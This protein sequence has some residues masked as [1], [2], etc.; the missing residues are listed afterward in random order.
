VLFAQRRIFTGLWS[1]PVR[2][3]A[4]LY[5][6]MLGEAWNTLPPAVR[7]MH[8][9]TT[10]FVAGGRAE[11]KRGANILAKLVFRLIGSPPSGSDVPVTVAFRMK[12][13][14]ELWTRNFAGNRFSSFQ[15]AG[16]GRRTH[17]LNERFGLFTFGIAL[18]TEGGKM[19][20]IPRRWS[21]L[22]LPLPL[23][24]IPGGEAFEN[25]DAEE[26]FH[27]DVEIR[28]PLVGLIVSYK[29]WLVPGA[30]KPL[31]RD[32]APYS[33]RGDPR[34][35]QF[36]DDKPLFVF[37][38][39]CV[40]CSGTVGWLS[41]H[42]KNDVFRIVPAQ[43]PLGEALYKHYGLVMDETFMVLDNGRVYDKSDA[44]V[45]ILE[46]LGGGWRILALTRFIPKR[47][48][49]FGYGVIARNR[50]RWFGKTEYC[51][52]IPEAVKKKIIS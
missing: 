14:G 34:V 21:A 49:D 1:E 27:F 6:K 43:S 8:E 33:Y 50:Y 22:G 12:E 3:D 23:A 39:V 46:Q 19:R 11:I 47:L 37:D 40:L 30:A 24:L 31:P 42:D 45:R 17:L 38:G 2:D 5:R 7:T 35:P 15:T 29:G 52:L 26:R 4:S 9:A 16:R 25:V 18:V 41:R 36:P 13:G 20:L 51:L 10:D 48:R 44:C 32:C 28:L